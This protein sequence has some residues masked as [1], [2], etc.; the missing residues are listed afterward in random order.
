MEFF[1][2]VASLLNFPLLI[3]EKNKASSVSCRETMFSSS[4][5]FT[6]SNTYELCTQLFDLHMFTSGSRYLPIIRKCLPTQPNETCISYRR[7][8]IRRLTSVQNDQIIIWTLHPQSKPPKAF[9]SSFTKVQMT[10]P[11][12]LRRE[13]RRR[14]VLCIGP[15]ILTKEKENI[16]EGVQRKQMLLSVLGSVQKAHSK[17]QQLG[18]HICRQ[19]QRSKLNQLEN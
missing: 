16:K 6:I 14:Q 1:K 15:S 10:I 13:L 5:D 9:L 18:F 12:V 3:S 4:S 19:S 8:F 2:T 7:N 11:L 17:S